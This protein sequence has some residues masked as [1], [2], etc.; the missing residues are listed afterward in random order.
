MARSIDPL[1]YHSSRALNA[2]T[3]QPLHRALG[4]TDGELGRIRELLERDPNDFELTVYSLLWSE[5]CGYKHSKL[6]LRRFPTSGPRVLQGPGENAGV[7]DVGDGLA[8]ALKVESHNHPSAVEPFQGAAT[9]VGGILRDIFAMGARPIAILD[10]LRFGELDSDHQRL[11]FSRV[12]EGVGHY[13]NCVGVANLGGEVYFE[14]PYERNCLVN[15]MCVGLLPAERLTSARAS[16]VGNLLVLYG[17][18]TGRDGIGGASVLASQGFDEASADKRPSVQ[19]GDPFMGKKL[20]ECTLELLDR[21]MLA[22]LQDL[23]A[24]GLA[25]STSEMAASGGVGLD[26]DLDKVPLREADMEPFEIMIS[27]SQERMAAIVEHDRLA[28]VLEV[29]ARWEVDATVIGAV[30]DSG[31]LRCL[32]GGQVV[33]EIPV[34]T[35]VDGAP[36]YEVQRT[37]PARLVDEPL[38][39]APVEDVA[40]GLR[41]LL[42]S[43]NI[44]SRRWIYQQYD[45]LVGSGT[46]IRPGGDAGVVRLTPSRR[47]IAV[48]LDGNGRRTSLDPRRGGMS[49]VCEAARNVA[50]TGAR[51]AAV[52]NCLN[53]G[54]PETGEVGY[55][56][57]EAIEGM[58]LACE[59][60]GL[61]VVS[62][63]VSLYNEHF[64]SPIHPTP[65]VGAVGVLEDADLAVGSGFREQGDV[66]LLAGSGPSALDGSEYQKR[67]LGTV[68]GR[69]PEPDLENE[70]LLHEFLAQAAERRLLRSAHDVADGGL[71]VA[72]AEAAIMG[73]IGLT[74]RCED[75]FGEGDGRVV[76]SASGTD[77][78]ALR[79]LAGS[80]PLD[81]IGSVGGAEIAIGAAILPLSEAIEIFE[82]ALPI[83]LG[84]ASII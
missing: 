46:A 5:H 70:R 35:L 53:F 32:H 62:G 3:P 44:A 6:L 37:R 15:A 81:E 47:A 83:A 60:L 30:T 31:L 57:A 24:A 50:C 72:L 82:T 43:P 23:G 2:V 40:A 54:N 76:I 10:S 58:S 55:E 38:E 25:S 75:P 22:S 66:V 69:I 52:T 20:I 9:G 48:S 77:V 17:S 27:E 68:A 64:G 34:E 63:N 14:P 67:V 39:F 26:V 84:E 1:R 18:R 51:P 29:C 61:P 65:V 80:L 19:I 16:G 13:G 33:G 41:A 8:V 59:A 78:A 74:A 36:R 45:Q 71:A 7:I 56:L 79:E 28:D 42:G 11:L 73:G 4:L 49:A 21:R 12:V